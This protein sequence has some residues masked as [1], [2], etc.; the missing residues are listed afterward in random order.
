MVVEME[1]K[2]KWMDLRDRKSVFFNANN[3][4]SSVRGK[5]EDFRVWNL[6]GIGSHSKKHTWKTTRLNGIINI[7][8]VN[9]LNLTFHSDSQG[10]EL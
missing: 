3:R 7:L 1:M 5:A 6:M 2:V 8:V 4:K 9:K 10:K